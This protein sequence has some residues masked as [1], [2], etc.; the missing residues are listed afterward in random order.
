MSLFFFACRSLAITI[1]YVDLDYLFF[2][3][4]DNEQRKNDLNLYV[5]TVSFVFIVRYI[6][7]EKTT[8]L[9]GRK[10][11]VKRSVER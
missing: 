4:R 6:S 5:T 10:Y 1:Q 11:E 9:A 8:R 7:D 2:H 3:P